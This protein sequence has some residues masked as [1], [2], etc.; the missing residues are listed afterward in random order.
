VTDRDA[1]PEPAEPRGAPPGP[2]KMLSWVCTL[3]LLNAA[4]GAAVA[5]QEDLPGELI[6]GVFTGRDASAEFFK[7]L[8]TALSPGLAHIA[9]QAVFAVLSTRGGRAGRA[10]A[11]GLVVVGAGAAGGALGEKITYRVLSPKALDPAKAAILSAGI[12]LSTLMTT[13]AAR[14]LLVLRGSR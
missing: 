13:L 9:A 7:G 2:D 10:G 1:S 14:R 4:T 11:A 6:V 5:I 8:G 3:W 12:I